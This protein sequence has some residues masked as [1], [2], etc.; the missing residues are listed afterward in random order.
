MNA[1]ECIMRLA[2]GWPALF[3]RGPLRRIKALAYVFCVGGNGLHWNG[4]HVDG[5]SDPDEACRPGRPS[6]E[7][8][9]RMAAR[10]DSEPVKLYPF[11]P[12]WCILGEMPPDGAVDPGWL[13][14]ALELAAWFRQ[15]G[16][17]EDSGRIEAVLAARRAAA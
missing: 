16:S 6:L 12:R 2:D 10:E 9:E 1:E 8:R 7:A 15:H 11:S 14:L 13:A 4:G 5:W 17:A 3:G